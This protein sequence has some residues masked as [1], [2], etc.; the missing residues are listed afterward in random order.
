MTNQR[1]VYGKTEKDIE[2]ALVQAGMSI[3]GARN[4]YIGLLDKPHEAFLNDPLSQK[5]TEIIKSLG[6]YKDELLK[7]I[8]QKHSHR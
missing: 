7:E 2:K 6:E 1:E 4:Y 3:D 8:K 5:A